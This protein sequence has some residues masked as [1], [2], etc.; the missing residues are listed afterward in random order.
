MILWSNDKS[1]IQE[2]V[3]KGERAQGGTNFPDE[4]ETTA[5]LR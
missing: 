3:G 1:V 5:K 2:V 4:T